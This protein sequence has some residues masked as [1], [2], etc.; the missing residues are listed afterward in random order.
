MPTSHIRQAA[1]GMLGAHLANSFA[2]IAEIGQ[3]IRKMRL[4]NSDRRPGL[5]DSLLRNAC[6][7][8]FWHA[9]NVTRSSPTTSLLRRPAATAPLSHWGARRAGLTKR[10]GID[11]LMGADRDPEEGFCRRNSW[12]Q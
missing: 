5:A 9:A 2:P 4:H 8:S 11:A 1:V 3:S 6:R 10:V 12:H 7:G